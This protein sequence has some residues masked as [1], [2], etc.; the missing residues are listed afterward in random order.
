MGFLGLRDTVNPSMIAVIL[1]FKDDGYVR[2]KAMAILF[3]VI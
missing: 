3:E 2:F 1:S